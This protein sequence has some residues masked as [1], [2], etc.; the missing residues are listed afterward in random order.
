MRLPRLIAIAAVMGSMCA[1]GE[2][3]AD[4]TAV[5]A[6]PALLEESEAD[7]THWRFETSRGAVHVWRPPGYDAATAG[8]VVYVHGYRTTV[9]KAWTEHG[10]AAQFRASGQNALFIVPEAPS[11]LRDWVK[12]PSLGR[13]IRAVRKHTKLTRPWGHIVAVGHSGAYRTLVRWLD[14]RHLDHIV[15]L[16]GLY[17]Q[18]DEFRAWLQQKRHGQNRLLLVGADTLRWTEPFVDEFTHARVFDFIPSSYDEIP[19]EQRRG[20]LLYLRSQ[21]DHMGIVTAGKTI[22]VLLRL[23]RLEKLADTVA[24]S[25]PR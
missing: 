6:P 4:T 1:A 21:F 3:F 18:E 23:T 7:G 5:D 10:L 16:D 2:L 19:D 22:P 8:I 11:G 24:D 13:L 25:L 14:Y 9:D 15:L 17:G 20:K 12:W